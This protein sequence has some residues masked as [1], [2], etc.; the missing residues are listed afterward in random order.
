MVWSFGVVEDEPIGELLLETGEVGK[1]QVFV[2]VDEGFVDGATVAFG[3]DVHCRRLGLGLPRR[4]LPFREGLGEARLEF[5]TRARAEDLAVHV[6]GLPPSSWK[7]FFQRRA[8]CGPPKG[9]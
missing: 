8:F 9:A 1:E 2:V 4:V 6:A 5:G 7:G 3:R